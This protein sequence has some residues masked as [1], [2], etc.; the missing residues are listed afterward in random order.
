[1][2]SMKE[3]V[4]FERIAI[5]QILFSYNAGKSKAELVS[6]SLCSMI[7]TDRDTILNNVTGLIH[8]DD[9]ECLSAGF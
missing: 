3:C 1:M 2:L 7:G 9:V 6:D 5:P 4:F 8:P